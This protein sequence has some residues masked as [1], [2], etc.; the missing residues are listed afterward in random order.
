M[1]CVGC[2][3]KI[4]TGEF[5]TLNGGALVRTK[6]D[7]IG[8][9]GLIRKPKYGLESI[10]ASMGDKNLL[11]FLSVHNHFDSKKNYRSFTISHDAPNGQFEFYACSHKCLAN[12]MTRQIMLLRKLDRVK[13]IS[14][15][16][17]SK[18]DKLD[19]WVDKVLKIL[20]HGDALV[21]DMSTLWD[22]FDIFNNNEDK[23]KKLLSKWEKK[24]GFP[25]K[26]SDYIWKVAQKFKDG[27][28]DSYWRA[29]KK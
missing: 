21:T 24:L 16:R 6:N 25:V 12:F 27:S 7:G 1:N 3:K 5:V 23:E 18:V 13:K 19:L 11:G 29:K 9:D 26:G 15:A 4:K 10:S 8:R 17:S 14:L 28:Y 22:F 2:H 20:G